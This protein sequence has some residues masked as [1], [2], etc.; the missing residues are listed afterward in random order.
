MFGS[1]E[2]HSKKKQQAKFTNTIT[3]LRFEKSIS[4][5]DTANVLHEW[6]QRSK[7]RS[8]GSRKRAVE[9]IHWPHDG[10]YEHQ[11]PYNSP[12]FEDLKHWEL[13]ECLGRSRFFH[14]FDIFFWLAILAQ[15]HMDHPESTS[16]KP[17]EYRLKLP[18]F[19]SSQSHSR[20]SMEKDHRFVKCFYIIQRASLHLTPKSL[21]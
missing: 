4:T 1:S 21:L 2:M 19:P 5:V 20:T 10:I 17:A 9:V 8:E 7:E 13:H 12:F 11:M 3:F 6:K 15:F 18:K 16:C 14:Y